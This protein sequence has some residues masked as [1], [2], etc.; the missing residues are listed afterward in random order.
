[1][2]AQPGPFNFNDYIHLLLIHL[3]F[4]VLS[5]HNTRL[6]QAQPLPYGPESGGLADATVALPSSAGISTNI[7]NAGYLSEGMA[8]LYATQVYELA[9]LKLVGLQ[10]TI[11]IGSS[12][13]F[14]SINSIG[15]YR[16]R[17]TRMSTG[18]A[19]PL[20]FGRGRIIY[21]GI[22]T[23]VQSIA[24]PSYGSAWRMGL[25]G[26]ASIQLNRSSFLGFAA[27]N[28]VQPK[29][30]YPLPRVL[31]FG[32]A[33]QPYPPIWLMGV[34]ISESGVMPAARFGIQA[35]VLP[36]L[37]LQYGLKTN[38]LSY[39][40]GAGIRILAFSIHLAT[41]QHLTL[42][43]TTGFSINLAFMRQKDER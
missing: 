5:V 14:F 27:D 16:Y 22:R 42:G 37:S 4:L 2:Y 11:P 13:V 12:D 31:A 43:W 34:I 18:L 1:M 25:S 29:L 10:T 6:A 17:E 15:V 40:L 28:Y 23:N 33:V 21:V 24:T 41:E 26:G 8:S 32:I 20:N 3:L 38:P 30:A 9:D 36:A 19:I 7:S 39:S 35:N